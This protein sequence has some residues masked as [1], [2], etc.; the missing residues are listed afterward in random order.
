MFTQPEFLAI[1]ATS[2]G[3]GLFTAYWLSRVLRGALNELCGSRSV[4]DFWTAITQLSAVFTPV[5]SA[6]FVQSSDIQQRRP[7]HAGAVVGATFLGAL[8][9]VFATGLLVGV[10]HL[11]ANRHSAG[12]TTSGTRRSNDMPHLLQ[13]MREVRAREVLRSSSTLTEP[14]NPK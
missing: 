14:P 10:A 1:L 12:T 5:V 3:V 7:T 6:F 11:F 4:I 9:V 2:L 8:L 13:S